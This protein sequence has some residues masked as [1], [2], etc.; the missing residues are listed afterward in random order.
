M[1]ELEKNIT[2]LFGK[3]GK[4]WLKDLLEIIK[5]L[6]KNW[7]LKNLQP[8][9]NMTWNYVA[10]ATSA[11]NGNVV[12]KISCD[13]KL[14]H[15]EVQSL[16]HFS[17]HGIIKLIE[18]DTKYHAILLQQAMP[19]KSLLSI[20]PNKVKQ[21]IHYYNN[22]VKQLIS[23]P[24]INK[25]SFNH[26]RDWLKAFDS[27]DKTK[28]P[29]GLLERAIDLSDKLFELAN[30]EF[31]LHGDLHNDNIL[32]NG[33]NWIAI[34]PKGI[35]GEIEF[36]IACFDFIDKSELNNSDLHSL[37]E[38]RSKLLAKNLNLDHQRL[39]DWVFVRL[40][41]G[42]CWMIEDGGKADMFFKQANN[43]F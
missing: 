16:R 8:V 19:G 4:Q 10:K 2:N 26:V 32:S 12:I 37:F 24:Q 1:Q 40:V 14:L 36:E 30:E 25:S 20:Y 28:F 23:V 5:I 41:L 11:A 35:V 17:G 6:A 33:D 29:T 3:L 31:V 7:Q 13:E 15:D 27:A 21:T 22:V 38:E 42:A 34:D 18:H 9:D 43:I 39:K